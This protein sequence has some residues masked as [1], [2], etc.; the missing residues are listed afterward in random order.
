MKPDRDMVE[1]YVTAVRKAVAK[2]C[3]ADG[4]YS[5]E[6]GCRR[7]GREFGYGM[8]EFGQV[9]YDEISST[10]TTLCKKVYGSPPPLDESEWSLTVRSGFAEFAAKR[11]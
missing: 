11:R 9:G 2:Y 8:G 7:L 3:G 4:I 10:Y 6:D 5:G 1:T